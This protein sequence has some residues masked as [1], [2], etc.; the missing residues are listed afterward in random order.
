MVDG[1]LSYREDADLK[2]HLDRLADNVRVQ[3]RDEDRRD[4]YAR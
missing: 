2:R 3:L 1:R 4:S